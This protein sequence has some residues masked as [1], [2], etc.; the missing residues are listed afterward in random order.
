MSD[1]IK[2]DYSSMDLAY[3]EMKR[4]NDAVLAQLDVLQQEAQKVLA[5]NGDY[6]TNYDQ[7]AQKVRDGITE[8]N[9]VT[10]KRSNDLADMFG[11]Y[12]ATDR[13]LGGM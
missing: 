12:Q 7:K 9:D 11:D 6:V 3:D 13:K 1:F 4:I 2:Y 8:L 5:F 10:V